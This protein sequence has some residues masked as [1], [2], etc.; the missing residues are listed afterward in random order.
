[1]AR[2]ESTV[3]LID[4][5]QFVCSLQVVRVHRT[6]FLF[7]LQRASAKDLSRQ[8]TDLVPTAKDGGFPNVNERGHDARAYSE[9]NLILSVL[10]RLIFTPKSAEKSLQFDTKET[11]TR[12][13]LMRFYADKPNPICFFGSLH[14][15]IACSAM[16]RSATSLRRNFR[17]C[18]GRT[19]P[20]MSWWPSSGLSRQR[21]RRR[22]CCPNLALD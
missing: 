21:L 11:V 4:S 3:W 18:N 14:V 6:V 16:A 10:A 17:S 15:F 19:W 13:S 9:F 20:Q 22:T 7:Q 12:P 1:M 8:E 2:S 5:F